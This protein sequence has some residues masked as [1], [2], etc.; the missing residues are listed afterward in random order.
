MGG[1]EEERLKESKVNWCLGLDVFHT[2][3]HVDAD[4]SNTVKNKYFISFTHVHAHT[5]VVGMDAVT[6]CANCS[7]KTFFE[8]WKSGKKM[9]LVRYPYRCLACVGRFLCEFIIFELCYVVCV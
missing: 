6:D 3:S 4:A 5:Q 1:R 9:L 8:Y 7:S 2:H